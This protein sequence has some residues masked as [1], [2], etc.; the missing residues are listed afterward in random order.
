MNINAIAQE[1]HQINVEKGFWE[2]RATKNIGEVLM[3]IVSELSEALEAHRKDHWSVK[4][5]EFQNKFAL[6]ESDETLWKTLFETHVK[7]T[8]ED[9]IAD[10]VIRILD[11]C[12]GLDIDVEW[13]ITQK[14][15]YNKMRPYKHGK[16]Y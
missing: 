4:K 12:A 2:D 7:N 10:T 3:L 15:K 5:E 1:I 11:V 9:E 13:H 6:S 14:M 16:A 8:F